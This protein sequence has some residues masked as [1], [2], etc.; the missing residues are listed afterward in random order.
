MPRSG[1]PG[2]SSIIALLDSPFGPGTQ[3]YLDQIAIRKLN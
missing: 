1:R 2:K 3:N